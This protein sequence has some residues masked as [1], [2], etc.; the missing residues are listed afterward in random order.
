[1]IATDVLLLGLSLAASPAAAPYEVEW[2]YPTTSLSHAVTLYPDALAPT[3]IVV[4]DKQTV[5]RLD[6]TGK[7]RWQVA[8]ACATPATVADL[9][10]DG[11]T[12]VIVCLEDGRLLCLDENGDQ[13]WQ[14]SLGARGGGFKTV[15]A[16]DVHESPGLE[17]LV[18]LNDGWLHCVS[19]RGKPL[20]R[21]WGDKFTVGPA[22]VGDVDGD[23]H[24]DVVYG[25]DNGHIYCLTGNGR[26][27]WRYSE[28]APYGRSGPNIADLDGDGR[29]EILITRSNVGVATCLM[30]LDSTGRYLWRTRD[31]MQGYV[32]NATIDLDGDGILETVHA[33][34]SNSVYCTEADGSERWRTQLAGHGLFWAPAV[35][36]IDGDGSLELVVC[37][38]GSDPE[39]GACVHV[40]G[41]DGKVRQRLDLGGSANAGSA[42]GDIDRDGELEV[43]V[44]TE[45]PNQIQVLTW[46]AAGAVAWPSLR[47]D[48]QMSGRAANVP[49]GRPRPVKPPTEEPLPVRSA[50][51]G[52]N[53]AKL[54]W[55]EPGAEPGSPERAEGERA[56]EPARR[57]SGPGGE[58]PEQKSPDRFLELSVAGADGSRQT[59]IHALPP[60]ATRY[61]VPWTLQQAGDSEVSARIITSRSRHGGAE[62]TR[63]ISSQRWLARA[64]DPLRHTAGDL[65]GAVRRAQETGLAKD[66]LVGG[67]ALQRALFHA[68]RDVLSA[69]LAR[70]APAADVAAA[71][72][73]LRRQAAHLAK[74][75]GL[76][77]EFWRD[78]HGGSFVYWP[79]TNPW[80]RFDPAALPN[81]FAEQTPVRVTA[82]GDE[83]EDTA[84]TLLNT[85]ANPIEVRCTFSKPPTKAARPVAEPE[86]ARHVTLRR[87]VRVPSNKSG[88]VNDALPELDRSRTI[89]L[90][91]FAA[92]QVWLVVDSHGLEPGL[93]E[94]ALSL[95]SLEQTPTFRSVPVTIEVWPVRLPTGAHDKMHWV[96]IDRRETSDQQLQDMLEHR[97][98]VAYG[99]HLPAVPVDADG[100][101][102]GPIDWRELDANLARVPDYFR[103]LWSSP[104]ARRWPKGVA[105][106]K[107]S[108]QWRSGFKTAVRELA[109]HLTAIGWGYDRWA[110]YP[111]DEPWLTGFTQVPVLRNFC[112]LVKEADPAVQNYTDP[113]G[114]VRAEYL[115]EFKDLVD[116]WQPEFNQLKRSKELV[117][118]FQQNA[119]RFWAYEATDPGKDLLPLGYYRGNGWLSTLFGLDGDGFW[120]YKYY[121]IWWP[122]GTAHWSIVYQTNDQVVPSRRWEASRD[123]VE[124]YLAFKVLRREIDT[125]RAA[126]HEADAQRA[127]ALTDEALA[128]IIA[129]QARTIDEITRQTRDYELD[130]DKLLEY[131]ARVAAEIVRL[132]QL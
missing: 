105:V 50:F 30:A 127:E 48:S 55:T 25:T 67:L 96:G 5:T 126:G 111:V 11:T 95:G 102:A 90:A 47:G 103:V 38:R 82:F 110:F 10:A 59:W 74:V 62:P 45:N 17:L 24:V 1:M 72:T 109:A 76:L 68:Q 13:R 123:G 43:I 56:E 26:V 108:P 77:G 28:L 60:G 121:D 107:D 94:L 104:P 52:E 40:L 54:A 14:L 32:S 21:F 39:S 70:E 88:L 87:A 41:A 27:Q 84:F 3:G 129:W 80:D 113:S 79:D 61:A 51:L 34:K 106:G 18:G 2:T 9:D 12:A 97:I 118:W 119:K 31:V 46:H 22:A 58:T 35:A 8:A 44:A 120:V 122:L 15:L 128:T 91:P 29:A 71:A 98:T 66:R 93:H 112:R 78:G 20:W 42:I 115:D 73:T 57:S 64:E 100:R 65:A 37:T 86:L 101:R 130:F 92:R 75:A 116:I 7:K 89:T 6:G 4:A 49:A 53:V 23:G 83:W 99:P 69:L 114:L 33:D 36:D 132:R 85:T 125:A 124:D 117:H 81:S 63:V 19:A 16:G 131:R